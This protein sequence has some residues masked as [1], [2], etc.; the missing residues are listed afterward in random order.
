MMSEKEFREK[1]QKEEPVYAL[2][3]KFV[4]STV[5]SKVKEQGYSPDIF[6][7]IPPTSRTKEIKSLVD[8]AFYRRK[9]YKNPYDDIT[10]KVGTRFV[11]LVSSEIDIVKNIIETTELWSFSK[12]KD[13]Q[14]EQEAHPEVFSY[15]SVHY[16]IRL[17]KDID[18][19]GERISPHFSCEIQI[20]TLLQHACSELTHDAIYKAKTEACSK[21]KRA[22]AKAIAL[23][24]AT[25]DCFLTAYRA[26]EEAEKP[27]RMGIQKLGELYRNKVG[28]DPE[29]TGLSLLIITAL[30]SK[31][32]DDDWKRLPEIFDDGWINCIDKNFQYSQIH[33]EAVI[34]LIYYFLKRKKHVL[35][36]EWPLTM[37]ELE[38]LAL[39]IGESLPE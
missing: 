10:D 22:C 30:L 1:W 5:T 26:I 13:F 6:F 8:K 23:V 29:E 32:C 25:D 18:Y 36:T 34:I 9:N 28:K 3:G 33:R 35:M 16:I 2:L 12:D 20:R 14:E 31:T 21:A 7:K 24:D 11:V 4:V 27:W 37:H 39:E 17:K 15:E 19:D 38:P